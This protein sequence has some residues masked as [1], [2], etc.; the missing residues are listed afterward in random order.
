ML[1]TLLLVD[2]GVKVVV[3][4]GEAVKFT[5]NLSTVNTGNIAVAV[6]LLQGVDI[7]HDCCDSTCVREDIGGRISYLVNHVEK[8]Y[9]DNVFYT[10]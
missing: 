3:V 8:R 6:T 10:I 1:L 7:T 5:S 4:K 2:S 9:I